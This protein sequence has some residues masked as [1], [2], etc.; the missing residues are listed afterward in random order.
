MDKEK[1][2]I[3][4]S[5]KCMSGKSRLSF[6]LKNF[7]IENGFDVKHELSLDF[8]DENDFNRKMCKNLNEATKAIKEKTEI[9]IKEI[10][11]ARNIN[12]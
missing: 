9:T 12:L 7:L 11:I 5:G 2:N 4:I 1:I 8:F 6:L 3:T 10:Q